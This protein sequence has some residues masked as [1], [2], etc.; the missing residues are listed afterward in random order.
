MPNG[1][2]QAASAQFTANAPRRAQ[3]SF[4]DLG[5]LRRLFPYISHYRRPLLV[6]IV[7]F[8]LIRLFDGTVPL[9][10]KYAVDSITEGNPSLM[11]P[12]FGIFGA[13]ICRTYP[14]T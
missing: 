13:V 7:G 11:L 10:I 1:Q 2:R 8:F 5:H 12:A 4:H 3:A 9:F 14:S 6:T